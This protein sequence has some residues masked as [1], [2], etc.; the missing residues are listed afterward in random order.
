[1]DPIILPRKSNQRPL[2]SVMTKAYNHELYIRDCLE[3]FLKQKTNFPVEYII[4][5]DASTDHTADIIREYYEKRPDLFHVIIQRENQFS[6]KKPT[7]PWIYEMTQG[8]YIAV[9][10]GDDYWID[11]LKLQKQFDFMEANTNYSFCF[12]NAIIQNMRTGKMETMNKRKIKSNMLQL[13]GIMSNG[14]GGIPSAS[15]FYRK[16]KRENFMIYAKNCPVGDFPLK[17][18]L[19][20]N[21]KVHYFHE[22]MSVYR[23]FSRGSWSERNEFKSEEAIKTYNRE[24]SWLDY[25]SSKIES[26]NDIDCAKGHIYMK[27]Y[28]I[29]QDY[30]EA[31][32]NPYVTAYINSKPLF[33]RMKIYLKIYFPIIARTKQIIKDIILT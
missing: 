23:L 18:C 31:P 16:D 12:H 15:M 25:L 29:N 10:E 11:P 28:E 9:C 26:K 13:G 22:T 5:D 20:H 8:K 19:A 7:S 21:G 4:H 30:R 3:G 2:V 24:I 14:G 1:M 32:K 17:I 33:K 6:Q 27:L